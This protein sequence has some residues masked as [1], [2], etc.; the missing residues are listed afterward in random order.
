[1]TLST[2]IENELSVDDELVD[3]VWQI[4]VDSMRRLELIENIIKRQRWVVRD[5]DPLHFIV[6]QALYELT[7]PSQMLTFFAPV[8]T[9]MKKV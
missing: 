2:Y 9:C 8:I 7:S 4:L 1:M 3:L 6:R 5:I